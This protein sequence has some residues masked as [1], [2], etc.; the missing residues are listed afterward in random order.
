MIIDKDNFI[1]QYVTKTG[2]I[3]LKAFVSCEHE[4]GS[5]YSTSR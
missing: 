3:N 4:T 2:L 1:Q 5:E